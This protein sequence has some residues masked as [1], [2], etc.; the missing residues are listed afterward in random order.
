MRGAIFENMIV[1][2]A[3]KH[4]Y[5]MGLEGGVFFYRDSIRMK[6]D[7]VNQARGET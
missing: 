4:R 7:I 2:E 1:M 6:L 5:N 3:I